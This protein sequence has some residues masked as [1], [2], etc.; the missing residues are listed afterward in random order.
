MW[1]CNCPLRDS[2][3]GGTGTWLNAMARGLLESD[4]V[5][6][7]IIAP[8]LVTKFSRSDYRS[9][10][11]WLVPSEVPLGWDGLPSASLVQGIVE[12]VKEFSPDL[13]HTWGTE[14]F[15]GLLTARG[16][17]AYPAL[18]EMQGLKGEV[19]K[20]F[21]GG[22][23]LR[24]QLGCIGIKEV[25]KRR[26]MQSARREYVRWG[27]HEREIL[28]GHG[29]VDVQSAWVAA[30]VKAVNP[31]ACLFPIDLALRQPFYDA[32]RWRAPDRATVF[33]TAAC[34]SPFKGLHV[35][36]RAL[37]LL[38]KRIPDVCLRIAG[39]H[40]RAG[41]RQEGYMRWINRMIQELGLVDSITW[42][43]PL[44]AEQIVV[45]LRKAAV[46][47]IPTFIE[48]CC[49]AMQEAMAIGTPAVV[50]YAGGIPSLGKD[51]VSCLFFPLG[52]EAMCATQLERVLTDRE[53]AL[54]L[55]QQSQKTAIVRNDRHRIVQRQLEIYN[56]V[57]KHD[58]SS[59]MR[60]EAVYAR[61]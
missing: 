57:M 48:N 56:E 6:L 21:C 33:C 11:Q 51:E 29:F 3:A 36:V 49:T 2:D 8:G 7:G 50:S 14:S 1:L 37:A 23:T 32:E 31:E 18:L 5:E 45:E 55:S 41:I 4:S 59:K 10:K 20:V 12:A 17:L 40:Q 25:L 38:K 27:I 9:V 54:R 24:E 52:D 16:L 28:R 46:L 30:H 60:T 61:D 58:V 44:N 13:T 47:V 53:L 43:G 19:A 35:A 39:A 42:L 26:T 15:W 22:L 34:S